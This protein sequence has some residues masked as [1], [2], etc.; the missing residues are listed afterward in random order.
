[1]PVK[2]SAVT[3]VIGQPTFPLV[4]IS[5]PRCFHIHTLGHVVRVLSELE[6]SV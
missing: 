6:P 1:M 3:L 4:F 5:V 2:C